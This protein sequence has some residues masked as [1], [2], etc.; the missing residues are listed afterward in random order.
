[1][2]GFQLYVSACDSTRPSAVPANLLLEVPFATGTF[3]DSD[4]A[5][6]FPSIQVSI[7]R[8]TNNTLARSGANRNAPGATLTVTRLVGVED[9]SLPW[10]VAE[11]AFSI[12]G[13]LTKTT[14]CTGAARATARALE[15]EVSLEL[16]EV[17]TR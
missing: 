7:G 3:T 6:Y 13:T 11:M 17:S 9:M 10:K 8:V 1:M 14:D 4:A 16:S 5:A 2:R 12:T 15:V